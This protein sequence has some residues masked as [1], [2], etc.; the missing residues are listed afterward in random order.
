MSVGGK[1]LLASLGLILILINVGGGAVFL[2]QGAARNQPISAVLVVVCGVV[3]LLCIYL[4]ALAFL[5]RVVLRADSIEVFEIYR[6]RSLAR[7]DIEGRRF[8]S[9]GPGQSRWV[10][11]P[12][13]GVGWKINLSQYLK[14]DAN[15]FAWIHSLPD[16]NEGNRRSAA[17]EKRKAIAELKAR[18]VTESRIEHLRR[19]TVALNV[20]AYGLGIAGLIIPDPNHLLTWTLIALPWVAIAMVA[21]YTP[22]LRFGGPRKSPQPDLSLALIGPG[23]FL[24]L[25]VLRVIKP[26]GWQG[27]LILTAGGSALLVGVAYWCDSW[28]K[29]RQGLAVVLLILCCAY[30]YGAGMA[31]NAMLDGSTRQI[32]YVLVTGKHVSTGKSTSYHLNLGQWGPNIQGQDLMVSSSFYARTRIGDTVCMV[33]RSGALKVGWSELGECKRPS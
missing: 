33:L 6:R 5:Y 16:L 32:Y 3:T 10:L 21:T 23:L 27:P 4:I 9:S 28:L 1:W 31:V 13:A 25:Q 30:G 12:K 18:G 7:S 11:V 19:V 29:G 24:A 17:Q 26:V 14:T 22:Y 8:V 15:F 20:A 2:I